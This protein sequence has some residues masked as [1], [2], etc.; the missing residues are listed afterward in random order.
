MVAHSATLAINERLAAR[1]AA[2]EQVVHLGFGEAGLPVLPSVADVLRD[3]AGRN[4]YG[5]VV[6]DARV[7]EAAAGYFTRRDLPTAADQIVTAPGSKALLYALIAALPGDVV[8]PRPSWVTYAAQAALTGKRVLWVDVAEEAGGVPDPDLLADALTRSRRE[9]GNPGVLVLTLPDNPTG[10]VAP[11]ELIKRVCA[12][13]EEHDLAVISDEIY[14]D[15][16]YQPE[17]VISPAVHIPDRCFVTG[18]LSKSMALGGWRIGFARFPTGELGTRTLDTVIGLASEVWSSLAAPMQ[19]VTAHVLDEP[20]EVTAHIASSRALHEAVSTAV[21]HEFTAVGASC[22][23]PTA[24]FYLYPDFSPL[25]ADLA[26]HGIEG[27]DAVADHLLDHHGIGVLTGSAF[28]DDPTAPRF[29]VA[30]SLLYGDTDEQRWEALRSADPVAL[31]WIDNA[32]NRIR[33]ALESFR[34]YDARRT[35]RRR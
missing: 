30:T 11:A 10:T 35:V 1:R 33:T 22:R 23:K 29:R 2:G 4:G 12:I 19:E 31:P 24:A 9:G 16:A 17:K 25:A 28:G 13:A 8:L 21:H 20:A 15:V 7:R 26:E 6:G 34:R 14:R 18:G 5:P 27:A 32:L 3:A